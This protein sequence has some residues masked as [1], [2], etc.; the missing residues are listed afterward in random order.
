M[1]YDLRLIF[2]ALMASSLAVSAAPPFRVGFVGGTHH[3]EEFSS[4]PRDLANDGWE[5]ENFIA[6]EQEDGE[7]VKGKLISSLGRLDMVA[8]QPLAPDVFSGEDEAWKAFLDKGGAIVVTDCNYPNKYVWTD[9]LGPDY[10][11]PDGEGFAGWYPAWLD[12]FDPEPPIRTFP[13]TQVDGGILW[14][15]FNMTNAGKSWKPIVKCQRHKQPCAVTAPYGKGMVYLTNLRCPYYTFF[16]NMRAAAELRRNGLE[17][18]SASGGELTNA[19]STLSFSI[20]TDSGPALSAMKYQAL[21][22]ITS[23][24]NETQ[25]VRVAARGQSSGTAV[26]YKLQVL[27]SVRGKGRV[28]LALV[29]PR[30]KEAVT[31][32][33]RN[34]IFDDL[35]ELELPRYRNRVSTARRVPA[36]S[37]AFRLNPLPA[38]KMAR[39]FWLAKVLDA[40]GK[41]VAGFPKSRVLAGTRQEFSLPVPATAPAGDY[42]LRVEVASAITQRRV[43]KSATFK[44]VAPTETQVIVD[45][46]NTLLRNGKPWFPLGMYHAQP[47]FWEEVK[48]LGIDLQQSMNWLDGAF[49][50]LA[51]MKQPLLYENKHKWPE[52]MAHW[53]KRFS[54]EPYACMWYVVDEPFDDLVWRW[55]ACSRA[56]AA[57][58]PDHPTYTVLLYPASFHYQRNVAELLGIDTYPLNKEGQGDILS[59]ANRIDMLRKATGDTK[60]VISVL[61]SFG[62]EPLDKFRVM[63]Y[64]SVVHGAKGII[65]YCW[66]EGDP[67]V[68]VN[69]NDALKEEMRKVIAEIRDLA[70]AV[71]SGNARMLMLADGKVH[72]LLCG[73]K[74]TGV[75]LICVNPTESDVQ[76]SNVFKPGATP[77]KVPA[78]FT[79]PAMG[80]TV[81]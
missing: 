2:C 63:A 61:Q 12:K 11:H 10:R 45:Q 33:D 21:L 16:E 25:K 31:L 53:A 50:K 34:Q 20:K 4:I 80:V 36:I 30:T 13:S 69:T 44:I 40:E 14:Y 52:N 58:A 27:N 1:K 72:A 3:S 7:I 75:K 26:S 47:E 51:D 67:P 66:Q 57:A 56:M 48:K 15:H 41:V 23:A 18:V 46:D 54:T 59:V 22:E 29:D 5:F 17:L 43:T 76:V 42:T 24:T 73:N 65:W 81:Y 35:I 8:I 9:F 71:L 79:V 37:F 62:F 55:E 28:R 68:G 49:P 19:F 38:D 70:P 78:S 39:V 64:I 60:P 74:A 6:T 32:I 77:V